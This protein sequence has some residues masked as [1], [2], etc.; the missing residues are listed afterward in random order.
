M[1]QTTI[2]KNKVIDDLLL[3]VAIKNK[4]Y[5]TLKDSHAKLVKALEYAKSFIDG[6]GEARLKENLGREGMDAVL[7]EIDKIANKDKALTNICPICLDEKPI[8]NL[9]RICGE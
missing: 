4:N 2:D 5:A 3:L 7:K 1:E 8:N 6:H 9:H